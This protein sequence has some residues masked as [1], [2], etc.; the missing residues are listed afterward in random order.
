VTNV[1][2]A[3]TFNG[4]HLVPGTYTAASLS[5]LGYGGNLENSS[6]VLVVTGTLADQ[7]PVIT[8]EPQPQQAVVGGTAGF[9]VAATGTTPLH[10]QWYFNDTGTPVE[11]DSDT[12]NLG[13]VQLSDAGDYFVIVTNT[14]GAATSAVASLTVTLPPPVT[15]SS[16]LLFNPGVETVLAPW[17]AYND[18][19]CDVQRST[20]RSLAG[21]SAA[22]VYNR[23][24]RWTGVQQDIR[25]LLLTNGPGTYAYSAHGRTE[26][27]TLNAYITLRLVDQSGTRYFPASGNSIT[28]ST[29]LQSATTNALAWTNLSGAWLYYETSST[30]TEPFFADEFS[31]Q[32][33][34]PNGLPA[35]TGS[36]IAVWRVDNSSLILAVT[37]G[38]PTGFFDVLANSEVSAPVTTWATN[39][40]GLRFDATGAAIV[41]NPVN[42]TQRFFRVRE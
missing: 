2:A 28:S 40:L 29:W 37:N 31:L 16:N 18:G 41:T 8:S 19:K 34:I 23:T 11:G 22:R 30:S 6:G 24:D 3:L 13:N 10:Y 7:P 1:V 39:Q 12:L 38:V 15:L 17:T 20:A 14:A 33:F 4:D 27:G 35:P 5:S 42:A 32:K 9:N 36:R 21:D 26:S 25:D